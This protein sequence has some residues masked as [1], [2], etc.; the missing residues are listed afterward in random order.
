MTSHEAILTG[1][2]LLVVGAAVGVLGSAFAIRRFLA[3]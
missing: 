2:L 1:I 3:V